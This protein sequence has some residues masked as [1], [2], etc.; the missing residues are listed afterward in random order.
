MALPTSIYPEDG[1]CVSISTIG[2]NETVRRRYDYRGPLGISLE[3][4]AGSSAPNACTVA[5]TAADALSDAGGD[6]AS[7]PIA[8]VELIRES[9][10][11]E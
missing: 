7:P 11:D 3:D 9:S 10:A 6:A 2:T 8:M 4:A 5:G 1:R